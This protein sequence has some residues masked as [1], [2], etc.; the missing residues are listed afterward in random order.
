MSKRQVIICDDHEIVREA[1]RARIESQDDLEVIGQAVNGNQVLPLVAELNPDL[2]I[3]DVEMPGADGVVSIQRLLE[4]MPQLRIL[5]FSAHEERGLINLIAESGAAG[6]VAKSES[7]SA[8]VPAARAVLRGGE[9]FP[10]W[11]TEERERRQPD[12]LPELDELRRLR[13]LSPR[14][15]EILDLFA[16]GMR[17]TGVAEQV[18][19]RPATVYTH[20]RNAIHKLGVDSRTQA[21]AIATRYAFL[22]SWP[23]A[24]D[25][26]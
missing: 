17:A 24:T 11:L 21:V 18:G 15:R 13:S 25:Q 7:T 12:E 3:L 5:V 6:F 8:I 26:D 19:I 4:A 2:V 14:E 10:G 1:L 20:V 23:E 22:S 16:T 9:S